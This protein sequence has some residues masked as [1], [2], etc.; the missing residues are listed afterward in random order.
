MTKPVG[1]ITNALLF[2]GPAA[3]DSLLNPGFQVVVHDVAFSSSIAQATPLDIAGLGDSAYTINMG[4]I[5]FPVIQVDV[6]RGKREWF[7]FSCAARKLDQVAA[8]ANLK[9]IAEATLSRL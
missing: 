5:A 2:A 3:V 8:V 4:S 7:V 9:K 6:F 1:L